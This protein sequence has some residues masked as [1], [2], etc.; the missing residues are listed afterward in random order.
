LSSPATPDFQKQPRPVAEAVCSVDTSL[1]VQTASSTDD[2]INGSSVSPDCSQSVSVDAQAG[3][4]ERTVN[5]SPNPSATQDCTPALSSSVSSKMPVPCSDEDTAS[6]LV[7]SG[8]CSSSPTLCMTLHSQLDKAHDV[9]DALRREMYT[10]KRDVAAAVIKVDQLDCGVRDNA[11]RASN[12]IGMSEKWLC[13]QLDELR[14]EVNKLQKS[15]YHTK[16]SVKRL[17]SARDSHSNLIRDLTKRVKLPCGNQRPQ[18]V[19][20][21]PLPVRR[22]IRITTISDATASRVDGTA[23]PVRVS[24]PGHIIPGTDANPETSHPEAKDTKRISDRPPADRD[25]AALSPAE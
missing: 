14:E 6:E 5:P 4:S 20:V 8:S 17:S 21:C 7:V 18:T 19:R 13:D 3:D 25:L 23:I 22:V 2:P 1:Q 12:A 16:D 24:V 10:L 15:N 9:I 11:V